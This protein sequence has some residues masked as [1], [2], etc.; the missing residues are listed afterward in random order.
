M[1]A[2]LERLAAFLRDEGGL[3]GE[4][5]SG[6]GDGAASPRAEAPG[7]ERAYAVAAIREGYEL[8]G[9]GGRVVATPDPD[10]ALLAGDRLYALGLAELAA[11]G[12]LAGVRAMAEVIAASAAA[13]GAGDEQA[14]EAA[15]EQGIAGLAR[16]DEPPSISDR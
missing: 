15:W 5:A 11:A 2:P 10:L 8:H 14:A 13:R 16:P 7:G 3:L 1:T 6:P 9:G 12:D 4:A